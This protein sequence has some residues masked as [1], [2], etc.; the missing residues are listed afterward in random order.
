MNYASLSK[1]QLI[2]RLIQ[3]EKRMDAQVQKPFDFSKTKCRKVAF[4][5]AYLG[6]NYFGFTGLP[7]D[8]LPTIEG[9]LIGALMKMKLVPGI[10][11]CGWSR[12]GRT[13]KGVSAFGQ[14]VSLWIRTKNENGIPWD[15]IP[16]T[17]HFD[18]PYFAR[19]E[20]ESEVEME[21]LVK[22]VTEVEDEMAYCSMLN[23]LLPPEIRIL[24]WSPVPHTF[25]ARFS[26]THRSYK[27][28]FHSKGL[29]IPEMQNAAR[30]FVGTHD[31]RHFCKLEPTKLHS[32]F[33]TRT[34]FE[35][36]IVQVNESVSYFFVKGRAFL[37][38]QVR[39]MMAVLFMVG[40]NKEHH[41]IVT[42]LLDLSLHP[43]KS[44]KPQYE[45]APDK[46]LCLVDCGYE[47]ITWYQDHQPVGFD[48]TLNWI[49]SQTEDLELSKV[50]LMTLEHEC[51]KMGMLG[52]SKKE[53]QHVPIMKRKRCD[54]VEDLQEKQQ[55]KK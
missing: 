42:Q 21:S 28:F 24:G 50:Q 43:P 19:E 55:K 20:P 45:M 18:N 22:D 32:E 1:E 13:D 49:K 54:S 30:H 39:N 12:C 27:Y 5:L 16:K 34:I 47:N 31:F 29:N 2:L 23:R 3:L 26:C 14:V 9:Q 25:D 8:P 40:Q 10:E 46:P 35:S 17:R 53:K 36:E 15:Q 4:R 11:E 6:T 44:G 51:L 38:H 48:H 37:W 41:S 52:N 7:S 33:F